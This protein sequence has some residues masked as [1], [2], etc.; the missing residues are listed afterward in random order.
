MD[1]VIF[2]ERTTLLRT[3]KIFRERWVRSEKNKYGQTTWIVE[4]NEN[5]IVFKNEC[6]KRM[7]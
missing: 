1:I 7:I 6:K 4:G 2:C 3:N 5:M